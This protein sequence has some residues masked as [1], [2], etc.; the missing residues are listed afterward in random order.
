MKLWLAL[1]YCPAGPDVLLLHLQ[2]RLYGVGHFVRG[3]EVLRG[4]KNRPH[5]NI[6]QGDICQHWHGV[7]I[8]FYHQNPSFENHTQK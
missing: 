5:D 4:G 8:L 3:E 7:A 2:M 1:A 6:H